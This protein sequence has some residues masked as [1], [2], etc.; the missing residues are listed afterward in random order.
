MREA[1]LL[2]LCIATT[3]F[4]G[5]NI[6]SFFLRI[7]NRDEFFLFEKIGLSYLLG[8]GVITLELFFLSLLKIQLTHSSIL[9]PWIALI[10]LNLFLKRKPPEVTNA[11]DAPL[12]EKRTFWEIALIFLIF[13]QTVYNFFRSLIKPMESYDAVAIWGLKSKIIYLAHIMA[14][15]FFQKVAT[16][17]HGAHPDYPLLLPFAEVWVY[18]FLGKFNDFLVKAIFPCFYLAFIMVFY[19]AL[20]RISKN[21]TFSLLFTFLVASVKQFSDYST[22]GSADMELG[23]YFAVSVIYLYLWLS[24]KKNAGFL[25]VSF[26]SSVLCVWTKNEGSLLFAIIFFVILV[27]VSLNIKGLTLRKAFALFCYVAGVFSFLIFWNVFKAHNGL[28]NENFNLTMVNAKNFTSGI[29]KIPALIYGYQKEI[30]NFK[31]WNTF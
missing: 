8:M 30:F 25:G 6:I 21:R 31:K 19:A 17:F 18:T 16:N 10:L 23:I 26:I 27:Y 15:D 7:N 14:P 2:I 28:V 24:A 20:K 22:I 4:V 9:I 13:L 1:L 3:T 5:W 29:G 11:P 12:C